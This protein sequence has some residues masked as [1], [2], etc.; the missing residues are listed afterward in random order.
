LGTL[1]FSGPSY[2]Q[3]FDTL[4]SSGTTATWANGSTL[5]GWYLFRQPAPGTAITAYAI[6]TGSGNGGSFYSFGAISAA[7]R[8]LG[9]VGSG[10]AYFGSLRPPR[11]PSAGC[12]RCRQQDGRCHERDFDFDGEQWRNG[13]TSAHAWRR[14]RPG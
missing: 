9:G 1:A 3:N 10:G 2:S 14:V 13:G 4:A 8:A 12:L 5:E 6:G 11:C 7:D